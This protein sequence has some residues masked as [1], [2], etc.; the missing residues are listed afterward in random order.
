MHKLLKQYQTQVI[1]AMKEKF[2]IKNEMAVPRL[3]KIS[4]N[5]GTS[6]ALHDASY[7]EV[8]ENV[9]MR[10][11][12]QKPVKTMAKKS[13]SN[14]KIRKGLVV[15]MKVTLRNKRMYDF[16]QKLINVTLP[17]VS[18][19][20]GVPEKIIDRNGNLS[21]G[22]KEYTAFPEIRSDEIEKSHGLEITIATNA[23]NH[24]RG[25]E[26]FRLLGFPFETK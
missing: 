2:K 26:F 24:D 1:P 9:L 19:F 22:F 25:L 23:R 14:F 21:L 5:I 3:M 18:D 6:K 7:W 11:S 12:G 8:M 13:I 17:R 15:G 20:H 16:L 4:I 10:I